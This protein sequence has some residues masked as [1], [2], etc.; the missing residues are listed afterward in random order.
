MSYLF[1]P[2][3]FKE[4]GYLF[5]STKNFSVKYQLSKIKFGF[6][7]LYIPFGPITETRE[8]FI[9]FLKWIDS[10]KFTK[11]KLDLPLILDSSIK[12]EV[13]EM[14]TKKGFREAQY[15]LDEET[16][17]VTEAD[18]KLSSNANRN[19]KKSSENY[20][21][22]FFNSP[23]GE[24]ELK[25]I[26]QVY[27]EN[28]K[29]K[30]FPAE[31]FEAFK[32]INENSVSI[33]AFNKNSKV[34]GFVLGYRTKVLVENIVQDY[35]YIVFSAFTSDGRKDRLGYVLRD[36]FCK[37]CFAMGIKMVDFHGASR[38][39]N[40]SYTEFKSE[41]GGKFMSLAGSYEKLNL[42]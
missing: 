29:N 6:K 3:Q 20:N 1:D 18:Y 11:V 7:Y 2:L 33:I 31:R 22:N 35:L 15:F 38:T 39:K 30:G 25:N 10:F 8:G 5:H 19:I 23:L 13:L 24:T 12:K 4:F 17:I 41:F 26:Y 16:V 34:D 21:I 9:E 36:R 14:I 40:R 42:L 27:F 32:K 28:S 37:E